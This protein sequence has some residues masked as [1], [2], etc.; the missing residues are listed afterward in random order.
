[1]GLF[2][3][4]KAKQQTANSIPTKSANGYLNSQTPSKGSSQLSTM[5]GTIDPTIPDTPIPKAPDPNTNPAGYLRSIHA[6][7]E[8]SRLVLDKAKRNQLKHFDVDMSKFGDTASYVVSIIKRDFQD[9]GYSTIPPHGRWQHFDV[10]GRPRVQQLMDSWLASVDSQERCRRLIDLFLVSVLLDA[11]AGN[12]WSYRSKENGKVYRRSEGLAVASLEMFKK[13]LFSSN[14]EQP[15][16]VD[17]AGLRNLNVDIMGKGL[18]VTENNPIEGL[19]GRTGLLMRLADALQDKAAFGADS[20]PGNM[21]DYLLS[22]PTTQ[23]SSVPIVLLPTFW[24]FLMESLAPIWPSSRTQIDGV[25]IGDAWPLSVMPSHPSQPWE[26]I[27]PFHKLTQWLCYSLMVP[28]TKLL[29]VHFAGADLMTGLPEYRNGGLLIDTGLLT[30]KKDEMG[31]GLEQYHKNAEVTG[32]QKMEVVPLFTV[33]D[34]VIVEWRACTVGFLDELLAT[35]NEMLGLKGKDRLNLP[36]MLEAGTWKGGR[37]IAEVSRPNT[38]APP[39]MI[40]SDGTVF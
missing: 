5:S 28:M 22:H 4:R 36:Q 37:E 14:S 2:R 7:R 17:S 33:E 27:V 11:G 20:R 16:Q 35:V 23:A 24:N 18:Q 1:M 3:R 32:Q 9:V 30:L 31:R 19:E 40:L 25:S 29:H 6:V 26:S 13:G 8:R 15:F 10:G 21:L 12:K 39:I 34:D 38:K